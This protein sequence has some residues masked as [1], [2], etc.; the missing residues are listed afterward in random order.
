MSVFVAGAHLAEVMEDLARRILQYSQLAISTSNV[1]GHED[2]LLRIAQQQLPCWEDMAG[3]LLQL[4]L[5]VMQLHTECVLADAAAVYKQTVGSSSGGSSS[6]CSTPG[7]MGLAWNQAAPASGTSNTSASS[8]SGTSGDAGS[9][10]TQTCSS[11]GSMAGMSWPW[12]S[13]W[14]DWLPAP[15]GGT[16][17][18]TQVVKS[19]WLHPNLLRL[20]SAWLRGPPSGSMIDALRLQTAVFTWVTWHK[21]VYLHPCSL[22]LGLGHPA[23]AAAVAEAAGRNLPQL[24]VRRL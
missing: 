22:Q 16:L 21:A 18:L 1:P 9:S 3:A 23:A 19:A 6:S 24:E 10:S 14:P 7:G 13:C 17:A 11:S 12:D 20:A 15:P 8:S 4:W 2:M 5:H